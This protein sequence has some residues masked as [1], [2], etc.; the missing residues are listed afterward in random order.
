[1]DCHSIK[2][3]RVY[4]FQRESWRI[5]SYMHICIFFY[6]LTSFTR[7]Y[8]QI[9]N[10]TQFYSPANKFQYSLPLFIFLQMMLAVCAVQVEMGCSCCILTTVL[11][12]A[13]VLDSINILDM[14]NTF[15]TYNNSL[16][17]KSMNFHIIT[18][19]LAFHCIATI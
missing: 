6:F 10:V 19:S 11:Y 4:L 8:T 17:C 5:S 7:W 3:N 12:G 1:M 15:R 18:Q 9:D 14:Y 16:Y 2:C 13:F